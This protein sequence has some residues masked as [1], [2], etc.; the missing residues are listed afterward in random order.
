MRLG[1]PPKALKRRYIS[2]LKLH[3]ITYD[4]NIKIV[5]YGDWQECIFP[6]GLISYEG[7]YPQSIED[8]FYG[9]YNP[10]A[11]RIRDHGSPKELIELA[12]KQTAE[13]EGER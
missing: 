6:N 13:R 5:D 7:K 11:A 8:D 3:I 2:C 10:R 9:N 12:K 4:G 1:I